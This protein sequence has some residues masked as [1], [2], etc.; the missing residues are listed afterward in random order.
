M[1]KFFLNKHLVFLL[2]LFSQSLWAQSLED[3]EPVVDTTKRIKQLKVKSL[4]DLQQITPY[5][6]ISVL[7]KRYLPKTFRGEFNLSV[8]SIINH[9]FF[10]L[11]GVSA[12]AG[13]F[14][15]EDH[16][17]GL[18]AFGL[19]P[20]II[21]LITEDLIAGDIVPA[22]LVFSQFY[23]AAYYKWSPVFGKF[24][25]LNKKIIYFDMYMTLG[26]G[27]TGF[28]D[29]KKIIEWVVFRRGKS[30]KRKFFTLEK[31]YYPTGSFALGQ[32][33]ALNQNWAFNWELKFLF[34]RLKFKEKTV[35]DIQMDT[36]LFLGVNYYFPK[37]G[38]R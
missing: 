21:K 6:S 14:L 23:G 13:F 7:Q 3:L 16:S 18:E 26:A 1:K 9:T 27:I 17:F 15:R 32:V 8:A 28:A 12:R 10:Y 2:F 31:E 22:S 20:P 19:F 36:G 5:E 33:F 38:Y 30:P 35:H 24:A 29:R 37:A 4:S 34:T 25:F 11:G